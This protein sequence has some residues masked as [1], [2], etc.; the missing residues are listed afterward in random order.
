[1]KEKEKEKR[2]KEILI[3]TKVLPGTMSRKKVNQEML[4]VIN[5]ELLDSQ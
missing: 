2:E 1:V 4:K 3:W 5:Q